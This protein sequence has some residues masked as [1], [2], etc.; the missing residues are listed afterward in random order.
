MGLSFSIKWVRLYVGSPMFRSRKW[1]GGLLWGV[2]PG[3]ENEVRC[4]RDLG[5]VCYGTFAPIWHVGSSATYSIFQ[6]DGSRRWAIRTQFPA[7]SV[8]GLE[9]CLA[10]GSP[11]VDSRSDANYLT[12]VTSYSPFHP[13]FRAL[14]FFWTW[15]LPYVEG[16]GQSSSRPDMHLRMY[17]PDK[18]LTPGIIF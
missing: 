9:C 17:V 4:R 15:R 12:P 6:P 2:C 11:A 5:T 7:W 16:T 1:Y 14:S 18:W 13:L 8:A 3:I 10:I